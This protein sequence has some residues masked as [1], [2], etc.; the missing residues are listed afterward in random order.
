MSFT[1]CLSTEALAWYQHA[2]PIETMGRAV[3]PGSP[4]AAI[5]QEAEES[6]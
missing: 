2:E 6:R 5:L 1:S 3:E 4:H